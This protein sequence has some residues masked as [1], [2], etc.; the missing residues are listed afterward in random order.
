MSIR[1]KVI[2]PYLIL[3][4]VVAITGAYVVTKLVANSLSERLTNQ[5][6][7]SGRVVSDGMARQEMRH[8]Q[9]AR[10]VAFTRGLGE[11]LQKN[12][13]AAIFALANPVA[14]GLDAENLIFVNLQGQELLHLTKDKNKIFQKIDGKNAA[15]G[16]PFVQQLLKSKDAQSLPQR[17]IMLNPA[18]GLHYYYSAIPITLDN[19]QQVVGVLLVGTTVD[20]IL[21]TLKSVSLA[22]VIFYEK[23]GSAIGTTLGGGEN[24]AD[25]LKTLAVAPDLYE[26]IVTGNGIVSGE[27]FLAEGRWYSLARGSL[28]V[29]TDQLG[30]FAVVLP[31]DFVIT[32][33]EISRNTYFLIFALAMLAVIVMG[34]IISRLIIIN[35]LYSLIR[36][37]QAIAD[38]DLTQR[39]GVHSKDEI[40]TLAH[41]FDEMTERLQARSAELERAN[42]IL[43]QMDKTKENFI[44][45]SAHELRTPLT[46]IQGYSQ[47]MQTQTDQHPQL[48]PIVKGLVDGSDRMLEVVNSMLD[49]TRIDGN[50]LKPMLDKVQISLIVM[51]AQKTFKAA[52]KERNLTLVTDGLDQAPVILADAD[53]IY[54]VFYHLIMN[55]IKYTQDGGQITVSGKK[56]D[57]TPGV[58]PEIE[59]IVSDTGIGID[60]QHHELVFEKFYQTGELHL[61]SSGRT[62][63]KGGGPGLGL[64]IVRG[65]VEAHDGRVWVES[66]GQD[67]EAHLGS[68]FHIRLPI[69]GP[70]ER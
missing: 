22:D 32:S 3:T 54:K 31:L 27:N 37:S 52:L 11:A 14:S 2:F 46:L 62:K 8:I 43:E 34:Y 25:F 40:G 29:S 20:T 15:G 9:V 4:L 60:H 49:V 42:A 36:T 26:K 28:R 10:L 48:K 51:R 30:A 50:M 64:A 66:A 24:A 70:A 38:G 13:A 67:E 55:A 12:D 5:L 53:L 59:V 45:I 35:P 58:A 47:M 23:G 16:W 57:E 18:N 7:E 41:T 44:S 61:H 68:S 65:I 19:T 39:T 21:S 33:D 6:L 63:F 17:G 69:N 1:F 56:V